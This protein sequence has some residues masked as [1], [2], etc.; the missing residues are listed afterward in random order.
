MKVQFVYLRLSTLFTVG[1]PLLLVVSESFLNLRPGIL[2][3]LYMLLKTFNFGG[4][5][6]DCT[7]M[8]FVRF[9]KVGMSFE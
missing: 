1:V 3:V 6:L 2:Q 5:E 9:K 8:Y 7:S 4:V